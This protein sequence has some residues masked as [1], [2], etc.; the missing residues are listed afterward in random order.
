MLELL[1]VGCLFVVLLSKWDICFFLFAQRKYE[2]SSGLFH[3]RKFFIQI[4]KMFV[5]KFR[6]EEK[7]IGMKRV[8]S[9]RQKYC[10]QCFEIVGNNNIAGMAVR[11]SHTHLIKVG[12]RIDFSRNIYF[13]SPSFILLRV[14]LFLI[15][16]LAVITI[17]ALPFGG[18]EGGY[19]HIV[20]YNLKNNTQKHAHT[21]AYISFERPAQF[22]CSKGWIKF[23]INKWE[24]NGRA[25]SSGSNNNGNGIS[26]SSSCVANRARMEER[27]EETVYSTNFEWRIMLLHVI[28]LSR[29]MQSTLFFISI[30]SI[31]AGIFNKKNCRKCAKRR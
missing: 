17:A 3:V 25:S 14:S 19:R 8:S 5:N 18:S 21:R 10:V 29:F 23:K 26:S 12:C 22:S 7:R 11:A 2:S 31:F 28:Q 24:S 6:D 30:E 27:E 9:T 4:A 1:L 13:I 20:G 15:L 16:V